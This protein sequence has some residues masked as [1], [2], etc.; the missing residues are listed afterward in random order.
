M[1]W[2]VPLS[3]VDLTGEEISAV[4]DVIEAKW[5]TMGS[6]TKKFEDKFAKILNT[7]Y[8]YAVSNC[9]AALHMSLKVLDIQDG[10]EV[11]CP[12]LTF[13]ATSNAIL[14]TGATPIFADIS[15][16]SN[17]TMSPEDIKKKITD[18]T[19]AIIVVHYAGYACE[20]DRI[21]KVATKHN[22][23]IVEDCAH[24][25]LAEYKGKKLGTIGDIGCFS[26]FSNKNMTTGEGG[27]IVTNNAGLAD[28]IKLLRSHGMT[29]LTFDRHKGHSYKY[30]VVELGYN[31]RTDEIRS[32]IGLVQLS[33]LEKNNEKRK[34]IVQK[35][36]TG[37]EGIE[38]VIIPFKDYKDKSAYHI[39]PIILNIDNI[40][41]DKF[42]NK[43]KQKGIQTSI[44]YHPIH[45]F[46]YYIKRFSYKR[47]LLPKTEYVSQHLVTLP[48]FPTMSAEQV[49]YVI[50]NIKKFFKEAKR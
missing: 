48:L 8:A 36:I 26:F 37:L 13:V 47:G 12:S 6:V 28:R 9:T 1:E 2:K 22:L 31:Y 4:T 7:K 45:L 5:L 35:Y 38:E 25:P 27:M 19:K 3:D 10:D 41:R 42:M 23:K 30:D 21:L 17:L 14:Y 15:S 33:K 29:S 16:D 11:I 43:M 32:A 50:Q 18:K 39:F 44:H 24:S 34:E 49:E 20:M 40:N 46:S